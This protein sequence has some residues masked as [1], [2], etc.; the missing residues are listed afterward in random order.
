MTSSSVSA[1][2]RALQAMAEWYLFDVLLA[3]FLGSKYQNEVKNK[4][5]TPSR[6]ILDALAWLD[7][8]KTTIYFIKTLK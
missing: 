5:R 6:H 1:S 7:N 2:R 3:Q 4:K 8:K